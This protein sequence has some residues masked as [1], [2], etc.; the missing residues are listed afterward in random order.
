MPG[1]KN[2]ARGERVVRTLWVVWLGEG[3]CAYMFVF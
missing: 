3:I 2:T 1:E